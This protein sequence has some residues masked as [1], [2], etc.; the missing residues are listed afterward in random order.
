[1]NPNQ[2]GAKRHGKGLRLWTLARA[3]AAL[4]Y[5]VAIIR[6]LREYRL[7]LL[8]HRR[9]ARRLADR[10][11]RPDRAALVALQD[12]VE[13]GHQAEVRYAEPLKE[14][15]ALGVTLLDPLQGQALFPFVHKKRL[16]WF[17]FDLFD[18]QLLRFWRYQDDP[19]DVRR[20]IGVSD[21]ES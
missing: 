21:E 9:L 1:M 6:S 5:A 15:Q 18:E 12:A 11:G 19:E 16:A 8:Q 7:E 4:P 13:A 3:Q 2:K 14:L 10:P 20:S 17:L